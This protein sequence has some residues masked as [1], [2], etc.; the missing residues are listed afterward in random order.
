MAFADFTL[1]TLYTNIIT[2]L[3]DQL[4][5]VASLFKNQ[6]TGDFT[7]QVRYY[8]T[9][10]RLEYWDGSEWKAL[11]LSGTAVTTATNATNAETAT[12]WNGA[13]KTISTSSP[14]GG[15][16]GDVWFKYT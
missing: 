3:N 16:D 7:D 6:T 11:D 14:S 4:T 10:K 13:T 15:A 1:A 12:K 2:K 9:L 5:L 8:S